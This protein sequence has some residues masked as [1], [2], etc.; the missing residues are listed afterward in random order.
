MIA[1]EVQGRSKSGSDTR[2]ASCEAAI[3]SVLDDIGIQDESA[4]I[5]IIGAGPHALSVLSALTE[6]DQLEESSAKREEPEG[7]RV[8]R[9]SSFPPPL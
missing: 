3:T 4:Q 2:C 5:V 6:G 7:M 9:L 1:P 8:F